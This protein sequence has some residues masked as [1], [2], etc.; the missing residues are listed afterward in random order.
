MK[1]RPAR[2]LPTLAVGIREE[3]EA[4]VSAARSALD[5]ARKAG[6]LLIQAKAQLAHGEWTPWLGANFPA[7][8][9]TARLY[10]R[11]AERWPEL[12][13]TQNGNALP[14]REAAKLLAES[15]APSRFEELDAKIQA[16]REVL[17][18]VEIPAGWG[19]RGRGGPWSAIVEPSDRTGLF[20]VTSVLDRPDGT[21]LAEGAT[22]SVSLDEAPFVLVAREEPEPFPFER[23]EWEPFETPDR[24]TFNR[25][26]F[27]SHSEYMQ[28]QVLGRDA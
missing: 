16:A 21:A 23:M 6:E 25:I 17:R 14:I 26:L 22:K 20:W 24:P 3:H 2:S 13:A 28:V 1:E 8:P 7:S 15:K 9:R 5:H 11:V 19:L 12:A 10:M 27:D 4:A 18:G